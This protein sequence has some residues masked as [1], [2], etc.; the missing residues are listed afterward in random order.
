M[1]YRL[2]PF[3]PGE[4]FH[5]YT[6]GV[7]HRRIFLNKSDRARFLALLIHCLPVGQIRSYST[8]QKLKQQPFLTDEGSGL[9]DLLCYC[10]MDNHIHLLLKENTERGISTYL[11]RVLNAYARY[12]N[13]RRH[14]TGPL[15]A[16]PFRAVSIE[17]DEQLLHVSRYIHLNPYAAGMVDTVQSYAWSSFP[18]YIASGSTQIQ[19]HMGLIKSMMNATSY[20]N[21]VI[22]E[23]DF[24]REL[25]SIKHL[26]LEEEP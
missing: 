11:Q 18:E 21:F 7:E 8:A 19:C 5:I 25:A 20:R 26:L 17:G 23:A 22:D 9:V 24:S 15:F 12:F 4:I 2:E 10:L 14:R 6:R 16:G 1:G 13:I 3:A